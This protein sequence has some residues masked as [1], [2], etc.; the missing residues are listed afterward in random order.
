MTHIVYIE[1]EQAIRENYTEIF[2]ESG[3]CVSAYGE[4]PDLN[5]LL[6]EP[7]P[8]LFILD[9]GLG[10]DRNCGI[11][12]GAQILELAPN[13]NL[14]FLTTRT[15]REDKQRGMALGAKAYIGK[16]RSIVD[17]LAT[18]EDAIAIG[19]IN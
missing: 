16:D 7:L 19:S 10:S 12:L 9:V 11:S 5:S 2:E 8:D 13:A 4:P 14:I 1:D 15:D 18:I 17:I 3:Y 6:Q